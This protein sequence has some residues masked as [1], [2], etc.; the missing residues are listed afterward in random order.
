MIHTGS[1]RGTE[2]VV[3]LKWYL[4][5]ANSSHYSCWGSSMDATPFEPGQSR[6]CICTRSLHIST[7][8]RLHPSNTAIGWRRERIL[9]S[10]QVNCIRLWPTA[11]LHRVGLRKQFASVVFVT[12][13]SAAPWRMA[14]VLYSRASTL[15]N[16]MLV[17]VLKK[18]GFS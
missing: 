9:Y 12:Q 17:W 13:R 15:A 5:Q 18:W 14:E 2:C 16:K 8:V 3:V 10:R 4:R 7:R 6:T 1:L 11:F